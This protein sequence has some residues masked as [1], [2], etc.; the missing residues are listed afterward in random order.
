M[1]LQFIHWHVSPTIFSLGPV[2]VR[3]Y[4]LLFAMS[5]VVG[6][7]IMLRIFRKENIRRKERPFCQP[8]RNTDTQRGRCESA[9][10]CQ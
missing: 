7:F 5:F 4:G 10:T 1:I 2:S 9:H 8:D 3:W 6:Y